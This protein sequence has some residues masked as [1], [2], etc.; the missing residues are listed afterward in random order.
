MSRV[1]YGVG[2]IQELLRARARGVDVLYVAREDAPLA[3]TARQ[4]GVKVQVRSRA[5]LDALAGPGARHQGVVAIAGDFEYADL[6]DVLAGVAADGAPSLLVALDGVQ[7][8]HNLG[9]II[10]SAYLFGA[11]A[12]IVPHDRSARVTAAV[13]KTSAGATESLPIVQVTN[14]VRTLEELKQEDLWIAALGASAQAQLITAWDATGPVCLVLGAE[15]KGIRPLVQKTCDLQVTIPMIGTR[16]GSLNV[17]AA[18]AI[19]LYE[20]ARQRAAA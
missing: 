6:H 12:V 15:G 3:A 14:L 13:T 10:R 7:D 2:P 16:V 1:V 11:H 18:A 8:P 20:V 19:A 9:A 5:E 17:S 4:R